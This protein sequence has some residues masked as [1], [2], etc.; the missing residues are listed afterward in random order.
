MEKKQLW[1]IIAGLIFI[2]C[3]TITFFLAK[4]DFFSGNEEVVATVGKNKITR[5]DWLSKMEEQYG[6]DVLKELVD[7]KVIQSVAKKYKIKV[8]EQAVEQ[9]YLMIKN[10]YGATSSIDEEKWKEQIKYRLLLEELL[11]KDVVVTEAE[12]KKYYEENKASYQI[13][14]SFHLSQIVV[15]TEKEASQALK[16]LEQ[17]SKF[18]TLAMEISIDDFSAHKG[19]DIGFVSVD[20][21]R[22]TEEYLNHLQTLKEGQWS[23]AIQV[24]EG[25]AIVLLHERIKGKDFSFK[26]VKDQVRRQIALEQM[27]VA[28]SANAFWDEANVDWFY[29]KKEAY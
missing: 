19:G 29:G 17:G 24:E 14:T 15:K 16:E 4:P 9:E 2:N 18:E 13:P 5:Q 25:F 27:D 26:E 11:T 22:L 1:L 28:A 7:Q 12:L 3:L 23:K 8:P 21:Q 10:L 20:D 6:E